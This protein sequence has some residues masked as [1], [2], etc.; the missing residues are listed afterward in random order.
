M[1][2]HGYPSNTNGIN[3]SLISTFLNSRK[4]PNDNN[5]NIYINNSIYVPY[6]TQSS[7]ANGHANAGIYMKD[8]T[9]TGNNGI[10]W[11]RIH[12]SDN[13]FYFANSLILTESNAL[14]TLSNIYL[15][16]SSNVSNIV[17]SGGYINYTNGLNQ[18]TGNNGV[19]IR[20]NSENE[21]IQF[22]N[23]DNPVWYDITSLSTANIS[24][25]NDVEIINITS[26]QYLRWN[27]SNTLW[28]NNSL[29][30][31]D[32]KNP[33]LGGNLHMNLYSMQ[34]NSNVNI[35]NGASK[36]LNINSISDSIT[37]SSNYFII[38]NNILGYDPYLSV[39][40]DDTD[41]G[42][43]FQAKGNGNI[44]MDC[45]TGGNVYVNAGMLDVTGF[46]K[47]SI[48][49]SS[50][51]I[52]GFDP[53]TIWNLPI[54]SDTVLFDF[55]SANV[56]GTYWANI[57][58]GVEGQKLNLIYY[59]SGNNSIDLYADFGDYKLGSGSGIATKLKFHVCGQGASLIY[60]GT[61]AIWQIL[62]AG[63]IVY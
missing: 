19:G 54:S 47:V 34:I 39:D 49:R 41:I 15:Y 38:N 18:N 31:I 7:N 37:S 10:V 2:I 9:L 61:P 52:D 16:D 17:I 55:S 44:I 59:N 32:D 3:N 46:S 29:S 22:R 28:E 40:G 36:V 51:K 43:T 30:I 12:T 48:Y 50:S 24:D 63:A 23:G 35:Y 57:S 62:N 21:H 4:T 26:N 27:D 5:D 14:D 60:L 13:D 25:L 6:T 42:M 53:T 20:F 56:G 58:S 11:Q 45:N 1:S 8:M 33:T